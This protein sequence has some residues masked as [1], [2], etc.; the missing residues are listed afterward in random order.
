VKS[1]EEKGVIT[2]S[3]VS[4]IPDSSVCVF[5]AHGSKPE[6][7][8]EAERKNLTLIDATCPLVT[9]VHLEARR[10]LE[11]SY[12]VVY[13]G[14]KGHIEG[15]G[16]RAE[17][18]VFGMEIPIV[19]SIEDIASL[20]INSENIAYLTQ[21]TLNISETRDII[22]MLRKRFPQIVSPPRED[23]C[24]ATTNRQEAV[25]V[26]AKKVDLILVIGSPSSS[27]SN[28]LREVAEV[29]GVPAYL[30]EDKEEIQET[31]FG[32]GVETVGITAGASAAEYV[33]QEVVEFFRLR[34]TQVQE[35]EIISES[36]KFSLPLELQ[37]RQRKEV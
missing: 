32:K 8:E 1:L 30:I 10:F 29:N 37:K 31:W 19:E 27:N 6:E 35:E 33:V 15:E 16:V 34:G 7:Y 14:H 2:V 13:I 5:S 23:I 17:A 4:D 24:F 9:K 12:A 36:M 21:T 20:S 22:E 28:R 18:E 11:K 25:S 26:I 3:S